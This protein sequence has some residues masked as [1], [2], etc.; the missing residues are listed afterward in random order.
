M[1]V[2][3]QDISN[4]FAADRFGSHCIVYRNYAQEMLTIPVEERHAHLEDFYELL[5]GIVDGLYDNFCGGT[6]SLAERTQLFEIIRAD[7]LDSAP[8]CVRASMVG[9]LNALRPLEGVASWLSEVATRQ[10]D[11]KYA[12]YL[13]Q[14]AEFNRDAPAV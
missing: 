1:Q 13:R 10:S 9:I 6:L 5:E 14:C 8:G 3:L 12:D 11:P 4:R 7:W 2:T